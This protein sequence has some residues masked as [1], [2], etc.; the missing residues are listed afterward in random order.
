MGL[1]ATK[2]NLGGQP[3][4][5][6]LVQEGAR[7][8]FFSPKF[9]LSLI[10]LFSRKIWIGIQGAWLSLSRDPPCHGTNGKRLDRSN[11]S[12]TQIHQGYLTVYG[13]IT[14]R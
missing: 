4:P 13:F 6:K 7:Q 12:I 9:E 5:Q 10:F 8:A 14:P 2:D 11:Y 3:S 1:K